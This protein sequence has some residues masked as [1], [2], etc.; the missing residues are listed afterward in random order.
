TRHIHNWGYAT[1]VQDD[2]R[3]S[4]TLTLNLGLRYELN[5]I[6]KEDHNLLGNFD[7][8]RGLQ[9]VGRGLN[10]PYNGDHNNFAPRMG[11]AW[12]VNGKGKTVLRAGMGVMYE[13]PH[14]DTF[15]GQFNFN[16]DP[17]TIGLNI[18]PTAGIGI[19]PGGANGTGTI[20]AGVQRV[21]PGPNLAWVDGTTP[22][23]SVPSI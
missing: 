15:I 21:N 13:I 19:G 8:A 20:N 11:F 14:F 5:T 7:P 10:A 23:F 9:Q 3:L 16:N 18:V 17:G 4:K 22:V 12:D 6:V 1:F 2:W